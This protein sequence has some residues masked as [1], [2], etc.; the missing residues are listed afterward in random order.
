MKF[1]GI[2]NKIYM[3]KSA[4]NVVLCLYWAFNIAKKNTQ[5]KTKFNNT[6]RHLAMNYWNYYHCFHG[7]FYK[8]LKWRKN[9]CCYDWSNHT[10][11]NF[12]YEQM[13]WKVRIYY[14]NDKVQSTIA[15]SYILNYIYVHMICIAIIIICYILLT[16][17]LLIFIYC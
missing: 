1:V 16:K 2:W 11:Y 17:A 13:Y 7:I 12:W 4:C 14:S 3:N 8:N 10:Q 5:N 15:H 9:R 6:S